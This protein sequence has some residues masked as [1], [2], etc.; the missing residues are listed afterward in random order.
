MMNLND[1]EKDFQKKLQEETEIPVIV[2]ERVKQAYRLIENNTAVQ[3]KAPKEPYHWMKIGG[4]IAGGVAA[5]L[6]V[7]FIFCAVNPVMAKNF[8]VVGGLFEMLQ[9]N[10]SFFGD[11]SDHATTLE[12]VDTTETEGTAADT[13]SD[14]EENSPEDT[15]VGQDRT[16]KDTAY[17]KTADG[18]TITCSEVY[19]NSQAVYITMQFK[20][21]QPF[22]KTQTLAESG[23]P[24]ITL[25]MTGSVD[26]NQEADPITDD[27]VEGQFLDDNTYACIFRYDLT[28]TAKDYTEYNEKYNEMSQQVLDEMGITLDD[29]DDE[30]DEGYE[31]LSKFLDEVS[32][33]GGALETYIKNVEI[34]D[35]FNLQL[36]IIKV[37]GLKADYEW[38]AADYEKYGTDAGYYKYEGDWNFDIPVTVDDSQTEVLELNDTN[39]AGIGLRSVIR[40]PYELTVNELYEDGSASDCFMVALDAN[41]N[42]L[43]YNDSTGNCNNFTIQDRDISTVDI[44]ILDYIQY[45]DELKGPDNYN[46][47]ENKPE[48]QK[49]SNLLDQYA[50]YHKTLHFDQVAVNGANSN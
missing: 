25:D 13:E 4:R 10:V 8:P 27:H 37:K 40:T 39:D 1:N 30:T 31:L 7:G 22:P 16:K 33:R 34:P 20:S 48:G 14:I 21:G 47:N 36:D 26:F 11:F 12:A 35:T 17:T 9:D 29:L 24:V 28:H 18:L 5:V 6:A 42:K 46:N 23:R 32:A 15:E 43:P 50:K 38:S 19:A 2:H 3:K 49:W 44:Y 45:M 41:G